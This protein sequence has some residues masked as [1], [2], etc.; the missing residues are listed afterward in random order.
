MWTLGCV[1]YLLCTG[2]TLFLSTVSDNLTHEKYFAMVYNW[3][4]EIKQEKLSRVTDHLMRNLLSLLLN[5]DPKEHVLSH[6]FL[7]GGAFSRFQ[8]DERKWDIYP[9]SYTHLTLPTILRV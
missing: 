3:T 5:K 2:V 7:T 6:P 1:L 9:V 8:G 4:D